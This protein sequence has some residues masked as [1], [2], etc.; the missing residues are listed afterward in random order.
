MGRFLEGP[1]GRV[2][3]VVA[4]SAAARSSIS[5]ELLWLEG[6]EECEEMWGSYGWK[7]EKSMRG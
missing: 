6:E 7:A 2:F 5:G 3:P 1:L 4:S